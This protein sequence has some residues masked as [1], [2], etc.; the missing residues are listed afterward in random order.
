MISAVALMGMT[1]GFVLIL[2]LNGFDAETALL[3]TGLTGV[4][5]SEVTARVLKADAVASTAEQIAIGGDEDSGTNNEAEGD[6]GATS[7]PNQA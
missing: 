2:M 7:R 6:D 3:I 5:G 4:A 1:Y